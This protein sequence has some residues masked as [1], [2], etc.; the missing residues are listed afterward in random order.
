[1]EVPLVVLWY[2]LRN[3][4]R[5]EVGLIRLIIKFSEHE[6]YLAKQYRKEY[7]KKNVSLEL[8]IDGLFVKYYS[9]YTDLNKPH[10][11]I[12]I[13]PLSEKVCVNSTI[14]WTTDK[15]PVE[16]KKVLEF[17]ENTT[18]SGLER[19]DNAF[20]EDH[21]C[22]YDKE[23]GILTS[24]VVGKDELD[25]LVIDRFVNYADY[26]K[27]YDLDIPEDMIDMLLAYVR[28]VVLN[29]FKS[30]APFAKKNVI[31]FGK[32]ACRQAKM[33]YNDW[34]EYYLQEAPYLIVDTDYIK[35]FDTSIYSSDKM[36][37][38][39]IQPC[40]K[41]YIH[42]KINGR[43]EVCVKEYPGGGCDGDYGQVSLDTYGGVYGDGDGEENDEW[44]TKFC[45]QKCVCRTQL[46]NP[47]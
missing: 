16:Q 34:Y 28:S 1:M 7:R 37:R 46:D 19:Y 47:A 17:F 31:R 22:L 3:L 24:C 27:Y 44:K 39:C 9:D 6:L 32:K 5:Y 23:T 2:F 18:S 38:H 40:E 45:H 33:V 30:K 11:L 14:Q 42:M 12:N 13:N 26:V 10:L 29:I 4:R 43:C 21:P 41:C 8:G 25:A 15:S 20:S 35:K 36:E